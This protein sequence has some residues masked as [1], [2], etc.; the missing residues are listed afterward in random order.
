MENKKL[1]FKAKRFGWGW[2][3]CS[4]EGWMVILLYVVVITIH[5]IN[6][7]RFADSGKE[8]IINFVIPLIINTIFLIIICYARGEKP[9]WRWK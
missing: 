8:V 3:P 5:S 9:Y 6:I 4:W 2:Y 1:W 7:E